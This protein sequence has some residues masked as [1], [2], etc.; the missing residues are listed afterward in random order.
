MEEH[1]Q[2]KKLILTMKL[3]EVIQGQEQDQTLL[4]M[5]I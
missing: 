4:L 5:Y 3:Q 1:M 2:V